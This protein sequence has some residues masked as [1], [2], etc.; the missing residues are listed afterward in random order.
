MTAK[1]R[2][3]GSQHG[4]SIWTKPEYLHILDDLL[5]KRIAS[6]FC[7][8]DTSPGCQIFSHK[9]ENAIDIRRNP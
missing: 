5:L 3:D 8:A 2:L 1:N 7:V 6:Y 9:L 4:P